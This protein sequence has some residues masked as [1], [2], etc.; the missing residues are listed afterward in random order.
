MYR[1]FLI[2]FLVYSLPSHAQ[3]ISTEVNINQNDDSVIAPPVLRRLQKLEDAVRALESAPAPTAPAPA[4][5]VSQREPA[6]PQAEPPASTQLPQGATS[7]TRPT[8]TF[9]PFALTFSLPPRD[10]SEGPAPWRPVSP[11]QTFTGLGPAASRIYFSGKDR[12]AMGMTADVLSFSE[13]RGLDSSGNPNVDRL[14]VAG[15]AP[16]IAVH[17]HKRVVF[18]S[19]LLFENGGAESSN[20]VTLQKGQ[21]IVLQAYVDWFESEKRNFGVRIG[22]QLVPIGTVNTTQEAITYFGVLKPEIERELI[23]STWHENGISFWVRR[24]QAEFQIGVF[25]S[26]NAT[27]LRGDSFLAGGRS[28]GQNAPAQDLMGTARVRIQGSFA[29]LGGSIALGQTAQRNVAYRHG[30]F[31]V[32][33]MHLRLKPARYIEL[34]LQTAQGQIVDA[35][36]ISVV[37]STVM[38]ERARGASGHLA[39]QVWRTPQQSLWLFARHSRYDLHDRVP[40]GFARDESL[41]KTTTTI[42]ASF[43]P[44]PNWVVKADFAMHKSSAQDEEDEF[45]IGTGLSF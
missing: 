14:N 39:L 15:L 13:R 25:N 17:L 24:P 6:Q 41:N 2:I 18:N 29:E 30:T 11:E 9:A 21:A 43:F 35:D 33:E 16:V 32:G 10:E 28:H 31:G 23:P 20:T 27:G 3:F 44:L 26:L 22:H 12:V 45:N 1:R 37:N 38:G 40:E 8:P 34:F 5:A 36:S 7:I 19:Q 4:E 42:G